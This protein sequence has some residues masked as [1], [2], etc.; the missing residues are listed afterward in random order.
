[1]DCL[2]RIPLKAREQDISQAVNQVH[3]MNLVEAPVNV[4]VMRVETRRD[5]TLSQVYQYI[6]NGWRNLPVWTV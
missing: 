5:P 4:T 3:M 1:M 2:S 6:M